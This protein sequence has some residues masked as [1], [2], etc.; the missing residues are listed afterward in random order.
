MGKIKQVE[1]VLKQDNL[2]I[3]DDEK[4]Y[5]KDGF[6]GEKLIL[7]LE[8]HR[9]SYNVKGVKVLA[10]SDDRSNNK[11]P[12]FSVCG[13]C[14]LLHLKYEKQLA[15][16]KS[17]IAKKTKLK[18]H[19][20]YPSLSHLRYRNKVIVGFTRTKNGVMAGLYEENS[21][22][23][24]PY[25][26]C[27]LHPNVVDS[28]IETICKLIKDLKL[29]L[30]D[31][32]MRNGLIRHVLIRYG[33]NTKE[34]LVTIVTNGSVFASR[35][36]FVKALVKAHP[37]I[38]TVIQNINTRKTSIVLGDSERVL[39]GPGFIY[40]TLLG[41]KFKISSQSFYQINVKQAENLYLKAIELAKLKSSDVVLDAYSGI[42]TIGISLAN[43]VNKVIC[44][45][46]NRQAVK[47]AIENVKLNK[48]KNVICVNKDATMFIKELAFNHERIDVVI[49]DPARDGSTYD[50]I[51]SINALKVN[52]VVYVSCNPET[53]IR[54]LQIFNKFGYTSKDMY[55]YDMFPQT[56]HV[57]S[58]VYLTKK[59][60]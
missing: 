15:L 6:K 39:Y 23:I 27:L 38:T 28:I 52:R 16:K 26:K 37:E 22:N 40:D 57:E 41:N 53:Q 47:D 34:V 17:V 5:V 54:D 42:G 12:Y 59:N 48:L 20:V 31:E 11:C 44:V 7:N 56:N 51:K 8:K 30:Y 25:N 60:K 55:L 3:V 24:I 1:V 49:M 14:Q 29:T 45:E 13:G 18:V 2:A 21:H 43:K 33:F 35:N 9:S 46:Q 58:I 50:F 4:I 36:N 32:D 10:R 19:D